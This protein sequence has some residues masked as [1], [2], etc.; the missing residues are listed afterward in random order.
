MT[1][2][3]TM[4]LPKEFTEALGRRHHGRVLPKE[5]LISLTER[6]E[7]FHTQYLKAKKR[8]EKLYKF[9]EEKNVEGYYKSPIWYNAHTRLKAVERDIR[10]SASGM[11]YTLLLADG[12]NTG[13]SYDPFWSISPQA[14]YEDFNRKYN[15]TKVDK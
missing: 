5:M 6:M 11:F 14:I 1:Q 3:L 8:E 2:K 10:A 12:N 7:M 13:E 9:W 4:N 15:P